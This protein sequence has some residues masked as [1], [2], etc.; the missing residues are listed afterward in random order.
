[1]LEFFIG[2]FLALLGWASVDHALRRRKKG[3]QGRNPKADDVLAEEGVIPTVIPFS[4]G[5]LLLA[6]GVAMVALAV[7]G[8]A[9]GR[10]AV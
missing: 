2:T 9:V 10:W 1:M 4:I 7:W 6:V 5:L 3:L 8:W